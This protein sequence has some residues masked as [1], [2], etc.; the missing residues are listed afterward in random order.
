MVTVPEHGGPQNL[1]HAP[2]VRNCLPFQSHSYSMPKNNILDFS[3]RELEDVRDITQCSVSDVHESSPPQ[4][5]KDSNSP[6]LHRHITTVRMGSNR[7]KDLDQLHECLSHVM[8]SSERVRWFDFS[9]NCIQRVGISLAKFKDLT[10]LHLHANNIKNFNEIKPLSE[11]IKLTNITL[12][13][14][15]I[16]EH[17]HYKNY[18]LHLMPS[19]VKLDFSLITAQDREDSKIWATTFRKKLAL[20]KIGPD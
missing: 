16:G 18:V 17:K 10:V 15:P 1:L 7:L 4:E 2:L 13:G 12:Y 9:S 11:L 8:H 5:E 20:H 3:F 14:N 19:L 6:K